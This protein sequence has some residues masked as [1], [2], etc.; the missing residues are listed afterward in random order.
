MARPKEFDVEEALARAVDAFWERGFEATSL[1]DLTA[2][3]GIQK[4]SLYDTYG[5][6]RT[7]FIRALNRYQ[8]HLLEWTKGVLAGI[9]SPFEALRELL[10]QAT[11][12]ETGPGRGCMCI[13]TAVEQAPHD[14]EI[15]LCVKLHKDQVMKVLAEY[16]AKGQ[17][18]GEIRKDLTAETISELIVSSKMGLIVMASF[19]TRERLLNLIDVTMGS[20]RATA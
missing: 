10:I 19:T 1:A 12:S 18:L 17:D 4:A 3:M 16:A 14:A 15:A 7:L 8:D 2:K 5:D 9:P 20:I 6:K 13:R 11:P